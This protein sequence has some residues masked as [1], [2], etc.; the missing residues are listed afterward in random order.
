VA[1]S[2]NDYKFPS[3]Y[4][5]NDLLKND[6]CYLIAAL[7]NTNTLGYVLAYKFPSFHASENTAYLYDIE[8]LPDYRKK[9][10]GRQL[11]E[12]MIK[13]LKNDGVNEIW[14]GTGVENIA[15]QRLFGSTEAHKEKETF[16]EYFYYLK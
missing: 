3:A 10:I 9:G 4:Y 15:A 6:T 16:Y 5:L 2:D 11:I 7:E 13:H 8:V 14:L 1:S 12:Q